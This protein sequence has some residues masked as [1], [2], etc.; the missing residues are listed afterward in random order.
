ME[1]TIPEESPKE[2]EP[3]KEDLPKEEPKELWVMHMDG[4]L[5][6]TVSGESLILTRPEGAIEEYALCLKFL[7]TNNETEYETLTVRFRIAKELGV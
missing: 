5:S 6:S 4:S 2:V 7:T 1:Y 3:L